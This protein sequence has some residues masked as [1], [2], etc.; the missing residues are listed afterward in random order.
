M[1]CLGDSCT[2]G[3]APGV[4]DDATYPAALGRK[5]DRERFE[6]LNG[7]MPAFGS[8]DCHDFLLYRGLEME[9]D[10]VVILAGWND[11]SHA[12]PIINR[13]DP[14]RPP[15]CP[16]RLGPGPAR[17]KARRAARRP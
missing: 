11:H 14:G 12:H 17:E 16:G 2:F 8:L 13:P 3:Y 15:G 10:V 4:T 6:V 5:L 9:P 1:L 7:G